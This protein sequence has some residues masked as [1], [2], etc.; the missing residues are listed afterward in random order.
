MFLKVKSKNKLNIR[1]P[2]TITNGQTLPQRPCCRGDQCGA[3]RRRGQCCRSHCWT[4][5]PPRGYPI[6]LGGQ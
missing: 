1:L 5:T 3:V 4:C 6:A 2:L